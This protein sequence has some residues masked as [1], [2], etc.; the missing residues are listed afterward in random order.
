M[1]SYAQPKSDLKFD[2]STYALNYSKFTTVKQ[3]ITKI[4]MNQKLPSNDQVGRKLS[5]VPRSKTPICL[6]HG[7]QIVQ[8]LLY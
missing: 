3:Q 8:Y 2:N 5:H 1:T 4:H 6:L 7:V